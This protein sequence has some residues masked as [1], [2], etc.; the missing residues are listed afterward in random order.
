MKK[1][2]KKKSHK[3][4]ENLKA[5]KQKNISEKSF[6]LHTTTN[7]GDNQ[8]IN[9]DIVEIEITDQKEST[10]IQTGKIVCKDFETKEKDSLNEKLLKMAG[11]LN[12]D[13]NFEISNEEQLGDNHQSEDKGPEYVVQFFSQSSQISS[14]QRN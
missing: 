13:K 10:T 5:E 12:Y 3:M 6:E 2:T 11:Y 14:H 9:D 1:Q 7:K 8:K 4:K